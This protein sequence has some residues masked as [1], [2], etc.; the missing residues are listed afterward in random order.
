MY[1]HL[2]DGEEAPALDLAAVLPR[3]TGSESMEDDDEWPGRPIRLR[4]GGGSGLVARDG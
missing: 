3:P 1:A 4:L 2:L